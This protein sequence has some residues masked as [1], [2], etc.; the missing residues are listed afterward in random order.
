MNDLTKGL[1]VLS[2]GLQ[3][4]DIQEPR[5]IQQCKV[6]LIIKSRPLKV[7]KQKPETRNPQPATI[8]FTTSN[9]PFF[10]QLIQ[11]K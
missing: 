4:G 11:T 9:Y 10:N 7:R 1:Q 6:L 3:V 8:Y 2:C 5:T